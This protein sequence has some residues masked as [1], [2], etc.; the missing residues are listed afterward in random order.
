DRGTRPVI[1]LSIA[2][3]FVLAVRSPSLAPSV[4]IPGPHRVVGLVVM[5]IGLAIRVWAIV[6]LGRSF[7]TTVEVD[8]DQPVV[9]SGPYAWVRHPSYTGLML[10]FTGFGLAVGNWIA[11]AV[12]VLLPLPALL[13]RI[14]VEETEPNR[15]LRDPYRD[16][17]QHNKRAIPRAST[18]R[19][20]AHPGPPALHTN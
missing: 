19:S 7:R 16:Y 20:E 15:V 14:N 9:S 3:A 11:L 18:R 12:C 13:R 5:W 17:Q 6:A 8:P 10:L 4:G 2:A 1:A